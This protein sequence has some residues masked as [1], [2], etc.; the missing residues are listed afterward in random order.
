MRG[1]MH[2]ISLQVCENPD[3]SPLSCWCVVIHLW[4]M[5]SAWF[6]CGRTRPDI[7]FA[8]HNEQENFPAKDG[9]DKC[10]SN[11]YCRAFHQRM[12]CSAMTGSYSQVTLP[13]FQT[14]RAGIPNSKS[15]EKNP[16]SQIPYFCSL[17][18]ASSF[19]DNDL[20]CCITGEHGACCHSLLLSWHCWKASKRDCLCEATALP[21]R[22]R[23]S[24]HM[25]RNGKQQKEKRLP[26]GRHPETETSLTEMFLT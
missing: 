20:I 25:F 11:I 23:G 17:L 10:D 26:H 7:S 15:K 14:D 4:G 21:A 8:L 18:E 5:K 2:R 16:C 22:P 6:L 24:K 3:C 9:T 13:S 12:S 19:L 1:K